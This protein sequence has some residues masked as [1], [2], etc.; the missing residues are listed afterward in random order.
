[1]RMW[2]QAA[3]LKSL[4]QNESRTARPSFCTQSCALPVS[5]STSSLLL[6]FSMSTQSLFM[7]TWGA[8]SKVTTLWRIG[9]LKSRWSG[10][11]GWTVVCRLFDCHHH[12]HHP[13]FTA[14]LSVHLCP[15]E[16]SVFINRIHHP[17]SCTLDVWE[18][19]VKKK[20]RLP[21]FFFFPGFFWCLICSWTDHFSSNSQPRNIPVYMV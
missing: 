12:H 20:K 11:R 6:P 3:L 1:M 14:S 5:Q 9:H 10:K 4:S 2:S 15:L 13:I 18:K 7:N 8:V 19:N 17:T 21:G 16:I